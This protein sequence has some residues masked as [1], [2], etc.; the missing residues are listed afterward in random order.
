[1]HLTK[2][3]ILELQKYKSKL[4]IKII[5]KILLI[6]KGNLEPTQSAINE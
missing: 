3:D 2:S 1:M 6:L 5:L 4:I